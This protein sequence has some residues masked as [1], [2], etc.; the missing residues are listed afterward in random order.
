MTVYQPNLGLLNPAF[1]YSSDGLVIHLMLRQMLKQMLKVK[2]IVCVALALSLTAQAQPALPELPAVRFE[3]FEPA[4]SAQIRQAYEQAQAS[5]RAAVAQGKLGMV[6]QAYVQ[7]DFAVVCLARARLLA[8]SE[9]RWHYYYGLAQ[10][11]LGQHAEAVAAFKEALRWQP[12]DLPAQL[13]LAEATLAAGQ[14]RASQPLF[15]ALAKNKATSA[16]A[17]YGLG[18]IS[19][20]LGA[21]AAQASAHYR[22]A[23]ALFVEYGAAHYALGQALRDQGQTASAKEHLALSQQYKF[24]RPPLDDPLLAALAELNASATDLLARGVA[25]EGMG[26]LDE[27]IAAHERALAINPQLVQAHINLI[28]L[29]ARARQIDKAEKHY[30]AA[31]AANPNLADSHFNYG[32]VL[33]TFERYAE[34]ATAFLQSLERNPF[35]ADAH[36]N[37]AAIIER[38]GQLDEAAE[39][40]R[41]AVAYNPAHR[42]SHFHWARILVQQDKL[43]AAIEHLLQTLT[44]EDDD[45]PRFTYALGATY[46]RAGDKAKGIQ[47]LRAARDLAVK[48]KQT[49][50]AAVIERDLKRLE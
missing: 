45:T 39:H 23:L 26:K 20:A 22:Q 47:Y 15:E 17:H 34:A 48:R 25:L 16:Q 3:N 46:A 31:V 40:Y 8:P 2:M 18:Q 37:Y 41:Q 29:Y 9:L 36:Y 50:L 27:S 5:P 10:S 44:P 38:D 28:S 4:I 1:T 33:M 30:R 19:R 21:P 12:D 32:I 35:N 42:L 43:P 14:F 11:A 24:Q 13:R 6:L 7:Y 49:H